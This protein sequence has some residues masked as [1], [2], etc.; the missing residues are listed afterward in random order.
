MAEGSQETED[1][2]VQVPRASTAPALPAIITTT[3]TVR[4]RKDGQRN[5]DNSFTNDNP[6]VATPGLLR[7]S[8]S[9]PVGSVVSDNASGS[10]ANQQDSKRNARSPIQSNTY[11][12]NSISSPTLYGP[13]ADSSAID[14]LS[15]HIIKR[16]NTERSIPLKLLG[17]ASYE[18]EAGGTNDYSPAEQGSIPGN[19]VLRQ[20]PPKEKKYVPYVSFSS[21]FK[22]SLSFHCPP[23]HAPLS[24]APLKSIVFPLQQQSSPL[25]TEQLSHN[26]EAY[27]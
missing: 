18:A 11:G 26:N 25:F 6:S 1:Q 10:S 13:S 24:A 5:D 12:R 23:T 7:T 27:L 9:F 21:T 22:R 19:P 17:R 2:S 15:Q 14:P 4:S 16:T 8:Q 3:T 20:R